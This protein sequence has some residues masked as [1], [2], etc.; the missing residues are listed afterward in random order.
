MKKLIFLNLFL[1]TLASC[2]SM[3]RIEPDRYAMTC[4]YLMSDESCASEV[5]D[6][7]PNGYNIVSSNTSWDFFSGLQKK[8]FINCQDKKSSHKTEAISKTKEQDSVLSKN[9]N[10][11]VV[12]EKLNY[13]YLA[14]KENCFLREYLNHKFVIV[15]DELINGK[16]FKG[17]FL[18]KNPKIFAFELDGRTYAT[19]ASCIEVFSS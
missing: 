13:Y 2:S 1:L 12:A 6:S 7:C 16:V 18:K 14:N 8:M 11:S 3:T 10:N 4:H 17:K 15:S 19:P 9:E 5:A